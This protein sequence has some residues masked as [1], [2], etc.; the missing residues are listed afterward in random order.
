MVVTVDS[1]AVT[2]DLHGLGGIQA[3]EQGLEVGG[4][5]EPDQD[6]SFTSEDESVD[7]YFRMR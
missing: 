5:I 6:A 3:L 2:Y 7:L 4:V 1:D